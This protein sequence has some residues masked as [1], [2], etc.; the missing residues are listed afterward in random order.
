MLG[1]VV[2][3]GHRT[4]NP[5]YRSYLTVYLSSL[6]HAQTRIV[7]PVFAV[8]FRHVYRKANGLPISIYVYE[9]DVAVPSPTPS[10]AMGGRSWKQFGEDPSDKG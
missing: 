10:V 8:D 1:I 7:L 4:L 6:R 9:A 5:L 2:Q 3:M